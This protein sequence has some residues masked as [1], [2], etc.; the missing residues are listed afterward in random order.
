[1]NKSYSVIA[2]SYDNLTHNDCD[3]TGWSQYLFAVAKKH[4][5]K[6]VVDIACGTGKMTA[7]LVK[8]GLQV[9]GVDNS[10][11]MLAEA[12]QKC[13]AIF[14]EQDMQK[15]SLTRPVDM[16]VCV[17]DG[18]NYLAPNKLVDFFNA[19][20]NN[21]KSGAPFVFDV[22]SP[23]KLQ[24]VV[25]NNVFYVDDQ[26]K[27]LLWTNTQGENSV[28]MN[29]TLFTKS[30]QTYLRSDEIHVQYVHSQ[31]F[32]Q[33]CLQQAGFTFVETTA[34]YGKTLQ[35]DSLRITFYAVKA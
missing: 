11:Q 14:V 29:L 26:D 30:G 8:G 10:S 5:V 13:R 33:D 15:L 28:T 7:L 23:Y 4:N 1:M 24:T 6:S 3:Y 32:I 16:A 18:V 19:V 35:S 22:S 12:C 34:D 31:D 27:T 25:G 2:N 21:L 9:I 17:N 20:N